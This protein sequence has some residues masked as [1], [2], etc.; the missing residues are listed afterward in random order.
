MR[1]EPW[2]TIPGVQDGERTLEESIKGLHVLRHVALGSTILDLGCAEGLISQWLL[3]CGAKSAEGYDNR[4]VRL[5]AGKRIMSVL[6]EPYGVKFGYMDFRKPNTWPELKPKYDIVLAL[7]VLHK[8]RKPQL[9]LTLAMMKCERWLAIRAPA[10]VLKGGLA[11]HKTVENNGFKLA[12]ES[13]EGSWV[14]IFR[15]CI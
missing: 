6:P 10:R 8:L 13:D 11:I 9:L 7:S 2:F 5:Q 1:E 14:G 15:K 12:S 3:D 4:A